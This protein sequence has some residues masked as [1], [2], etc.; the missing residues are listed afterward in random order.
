MTRLNPS[1]GALQ[2]VPVRQRAPGACRRVRIDLG[3]QRHRR[4]RLPHRSGERRRH[5]ASPSAQVRRR[6]S[7][8]PARSGLP[9]A[10]AAASI[11]ST[12]RPTRS[13]ARSRW[14]TGRRTSHRSAAGSG[15]SARATASVH[16]GG[17]LRL[18]D[19]REARL[20][21]RRRGV[22]AHI[23]V[24]LRRHRRRTRRVQARRAAWMEARSFPTWQR[25]CPGPPTAAAPIP[26]SCGAASATRTATSY[27][28]AISGARSSAYSARFNVGSDL[29]RGLEGADACSKIALRPLPR[30]R[31]R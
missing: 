12:Q 2:E 7:R 17:T 6:S 11:A 18:F 23:V 24:A 15:L 26:S 14:E 28:R 9:T 22:L 25:H 4:N 29:Y 20:A 10:M 1:S 5:R 30:R 16:R 8:A 27:A 13:C 21:R 31:R 3:R 19:W